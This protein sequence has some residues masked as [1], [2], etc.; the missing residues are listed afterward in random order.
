MVKVRFAPSPSGSL[1]LGSARTAIVNYLF[2]RSVGG[3][4]VL[5]IEDTDEARSTQISKD[6]ILKTLEWL[7]IGFDEGPFYQ[8]ERCFLYQNYVDQLLASGGAYR[9][10]CSQKELLERKQK[11]IEQ[12]LYPSYSGGCEKLTP[13]E[14][15]KKLDNREPYMVR[16]K[17]PD[18]KI[19]FHDIIKGD[20]EFQ[21]DLLTDIVIERTDGTPTYHFAVVVDDHLMEITHVIRGED[22]LSNTPLQ[23][24]IYDALHWDKPEFC[25]LPLITGPD[26]TKLSKRH[27]D[28]AIE[29]YQTLG[30]L[31]EAIFCYLALLGYSR[32]PT[33]EIFDQDSLISSFHLSQLS[34]SSSQFDISNLTWMNTQFIK[35]KD[36]DK[37]WDE[38]QKWIDRVP[39]EFE[40]KRKIFELSRNQLKTLGDIPRCFEPFLIY[41]LNKENPEIQKILES[42]D[43]WTYLDE[44]F[45]QLNQLEFFRED[46]LE[47]MFESVREKYS[48]HKRDLI[49]II[50]IAITGGLVSP[51]LFD[52]LILLGKNEVMKR[53]SLFASECNHDKKN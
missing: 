17:M 22:H 6:S 5:R 52:T 40:K 33:K 3:K 47:L 13:T 43:F 51:P 15:Q 27:C 46:T 23:I 53:Y 50:R 7:K 25:H 4:L 1:H 2:A 14:V 8:S 32:K 34:C 9:C 36:L 49:Q 35:K 30:F 42:T 48:V 24:A 18:Q 21:G 31:P 20:L 29:D 39:L 45:C 38:S 10:F 19:V 44:F 26:Q 11:Q 12:G 16:L 37:L 28:T 41:R